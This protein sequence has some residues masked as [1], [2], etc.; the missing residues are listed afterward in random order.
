MNPNQVLSFISRKK[1]KV[2]VKRTG[3]V[4]HALIEGQNLSKEMEELSFRDP[5]KTKTY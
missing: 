4:F 1:D 2:Y 5:M 3:F